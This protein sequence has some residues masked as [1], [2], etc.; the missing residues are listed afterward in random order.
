MCPPCTLFQGGLSTCAP[1]VT[2]WASV[3]LQSG[4]TVNEASCVHMSLCSRV[5][6]YGGEGLTVLKEYALSCTV[7]GF[8]RIGQTAFQNDCS[9]LYSEQQVEV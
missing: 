8:I 5:S 3:S 4:A 1:S 6:D 2:L 9:L 7:F